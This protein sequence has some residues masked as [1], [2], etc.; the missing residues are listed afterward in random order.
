MKA[1]K[2][3][4]LIQC[5]AALNQRLKII[6]N[7]IKDINESLQAETKSTAGDKHETGRAML[8]LDREKAGVQLAAIKQQLQLLSKVNMNKESTKIALG[9]V[10]ITEDNN[11]FIAVSVGELTVEGEKFYGISLN[12]PLGKL[13]LGK[14][15][16]EIIEW[17]GKKTR[18]IEV[19]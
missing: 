3:A 1:L 6:V 8:H 4:L 17:N 15:S 16:N 18:I 7:V 9:S 13:L 19:F 14:D 2:K 5:E 11:Y 10:V 12:T